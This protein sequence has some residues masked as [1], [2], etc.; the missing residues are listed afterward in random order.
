MLGVILRKAQK[1]IQDPAKLRRL[2]AKQQWTSL[3]A[4]VKGTPTRACS[5]RTPP[6]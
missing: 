3:E 2:I 1:M 4:E 5:K 6:A